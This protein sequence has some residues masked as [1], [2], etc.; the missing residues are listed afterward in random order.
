[1]LF[2]ARPPPRARNGDAVAVARAATAAASSIAAHAA[3]GAAARATASVLPPGL[4][5][6]VTPQF[7]VHMSQRRVPRHNGACDGDRDR[8]RGARGCHGIGRS[9]R[10]DVACAVTLTAAARAAVS[11]TTMV[12]ARAVSVASNTVMR[13]GY[14]TPSFSTR[15]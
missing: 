8:D 15:A 12:A 6:G 7:A 14:A 3:A 13:C 10:H 2:L 9:E 5:S 4:D 11:A 1:M